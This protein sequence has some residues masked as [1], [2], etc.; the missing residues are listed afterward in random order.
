MRCWMRSSFCL[1]CALSAC[2]TSLR[3][4]L[5]ISACSEARKLASILAAI[6]SGVRAAARALSAGSR[7]YGAAAEVEDLIAEAT[8]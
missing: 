2:G 5:A 8:S 3:R 7:D 6:A 4:N 1:A